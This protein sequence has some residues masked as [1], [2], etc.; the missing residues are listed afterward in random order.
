MFWVWLFI[1]YYCI[2]IFCAYMSF[3]VRIVRR[4]V[5]AIRIIFNTENVYK[6]RPIVCDIHNTFVYVYTYRYI[7]C[8][9][10]RRAAPHDHCTTPPQFQWFHH[11]WLYYTH[12]I[13]CIIICIIPH[14]RLAFRRCYAKTCVSVR[15]TCTGTSCC[16]G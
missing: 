15:V 8:E 2:Y 13:K 16:R 14:M 5:A 6:S 9:R 7:Y 1:Y 4:P 3:V 12:I 11:I 10:T